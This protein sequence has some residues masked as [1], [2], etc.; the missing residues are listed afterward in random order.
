MTNTLKEKIIE[1]L[2]YYELSM[3][4]NSSCN[5]HLGE[6]LIGLTAL[7]ID[8]TRIVL[9]SIG[10]DMDMG[11]CMAHIYPSE[12]LD[13][14]GIISKHLD[15]DV[16]LL[17]SRTRSVHENQYNSLLDALEKSG[18]ISE[19]A[20]DYVP[21]VTINSN[22]DNQMS[23]SQ[24]YH[25]LYNE[26]NYS[27]ET[28]HGNNAFKLI[29]YYII[30]EEL[31]KIKNKQSSQMLRIEVDS[32]VELSTGDSHY[33]QH[34]DIEPVFVFGGLHIAIRIQKYGQDNNI[35]SQYVTC[36]VG[37]G[38][39][40]VLEKIIDE[41]IRVFGLVSDKEP[42]HKVTIIDRNEE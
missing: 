34:I 1:S 23:I 14:T 26:A 25:N 32:K 11:V 30:E 15:S 8:C 7:C 28:Y 19:L 22:I 5:I 27:A 39:H 13:E 40:N 37:N 10:E 17:C 38:Y 9:V 42:V 24:Y 20:F 29:F 4:V 3:A 2:M 35:V 18:K 33:W 41:S 31:N 6:M 21:K 12:F 16:N 36:K